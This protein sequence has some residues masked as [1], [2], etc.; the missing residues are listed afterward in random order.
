MFA[1]VRSHSH[2]LKR[3]FVHIRA[4]KS[5]HL[6]VPKYV[7]PK[8]AIELT[9]YPW[10]TT[11]DIAQLILAQYPLLSFASQH[12]LVQKAIANLKLYDFDSDSETEYQNIDF[13]PEYQG[14]TAIYSRNASKA[15]L[16]YMRYEVILL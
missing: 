13:K 8:N 3:I 15:I 11:R 5:A 12:R 14:S 1:N 10:F 2:E 6:P 4:M 7:G 9:D 16:E